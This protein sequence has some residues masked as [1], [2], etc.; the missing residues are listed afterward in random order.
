MT[1]CYSAYRLLQ[2]VGAAAD[3]E[4]VDLALVCRLTHDAL[5][6]LTRRAAEDR[7]GASHKQDRAPANNTIIMKQPGTCQ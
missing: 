4:Q 6:Q 2:D 7:L 3:L 5:V 1:L